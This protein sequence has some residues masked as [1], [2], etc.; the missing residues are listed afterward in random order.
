VA[1]L[2]GWAETA[3][4]GRRIV[5]A[6]RLSSHDDPLRVWM[7]HY[8]AE[9]MSNEKSV[10]SDKRRTTIRRECADLITRLWSIRYQYDQS[11]PINSL[12][13]N[14][15][16]LVGDDVFRRPLVDCSDATE[17]GE[18]G[19]VTAYE[20]TLQLIASLSKKENAVM[21]AALTA[22]TP[23]ELSDSISGH[24]ED[25]KG[26]ELSGLLDF[27]KR[28]VGSSDDPL[29]KRVEEAETDSARQEAVADALWE[30]SKQRRR[31]IKT[32]QS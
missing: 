25:G 31:L 23:D 32:L 30:L 5:K 6:L 10:T 20:W 16:V 4:L 18:K 26:L 11:D 28:I 12:N 3:T 7:A 14:I 17:D 24:D 29:L 15:K 9:P 19:Y 2:K 22:E 13:H 21:L 27:R 1:R 8:I